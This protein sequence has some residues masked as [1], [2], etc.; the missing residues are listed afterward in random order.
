MSP[1][2]L[3]AGALDRL[4]QYG[5]PGNVR[6]LENL[7]RRLAALCPHEVINAVVIDEKIPPNSIVA[8]TSPDLL[9]KTRRRWLYGDYFRDESSEA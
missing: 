8:G 5:W 9:V 7:M 4:R 6:E 3:D 2:S 1:G